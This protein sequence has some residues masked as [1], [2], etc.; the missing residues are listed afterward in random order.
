MK[1]L[2][3]YLVA[4][5]AIIWLTA[6]PPK[7]KGIKMFEASQMR[8]APGERIDLAWQY[9][10]GSTIASQIL[11]L[12][13]LSFYGIQKD[14][15]VLERTQRVANFNYAGA[16]SVQLVA[17]EDN[18]NKTRYS[19]ILE[20]KSER[21]QF[22]KATL[23]S[24]S[25]DRPYM[26]YKKLQGGG[27]EGA[28]NIE[29]TNYIAFYNRSGV[30]NPQRPAEIKIDDI[31][32]VFPPGTSDIFRGRTR[33][34]GNTFTLLQG[35]DFPLNVP[36]NIDGGASNLI[37]YGGAIVYGYSETKTYKTGDGETVFY[38]GTDEP[39]PVFI[40]IPCL[41]LP[42][43]NEVHISDIQL[44]N[45]LQGLVT[46]ANYYNS[47]S[48]FG[49]GNTGVTSIQVANFSSAAPTVSG[50]VKGAV[51]IFPS[52]TDIQS[53]FSVNVDEIKFNMD[54]VADNALFNYLLQ[55]Q[56]R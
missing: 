23:R 9:E 48:L 22:M 27:F 25:P 32:G 26:G 50:D 28:V 46:A 44:G 19:A 47:V 30:D 15:I 43:R 2:L 4:I 51:T 13:R 1:K 14:S 39:Q 31:V 38:K 49:S 41:Y 52:G 40:A 18:D 53:T 11:Y 6:C 29:F 16:V 37:I 36:G 12:H 5:N 21:E 17:I 10:E 24:S 42:T 34:D 20:V 35:P 54:L 56:N 8:A 7:P 45:T 33:V 55:P 3:T